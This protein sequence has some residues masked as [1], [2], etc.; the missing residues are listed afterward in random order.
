MKTGMLGA[1]VVAGSFAGSLF[2]HFVW[3][4]MGLG[5]ASGKPPILHASTAMAGTLLM[6]ALTFVLG[7]GAVF[8]GLRQV[9]AP[10]AAQ[11]TISLLYGL[12]MGALSVVLFVTTAVA[13]DR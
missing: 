10:R 11:I 9:G 13:F 6:T 8:F 4:M 1:L 3:L 7:T 12:M 5:I 2:L